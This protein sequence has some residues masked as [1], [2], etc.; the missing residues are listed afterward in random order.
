MCIK[1][2]KTTEQYK[3]NKTATARIT[4]TTTAIHIKTEITVERKMKNRVHVYKVI[5]MVS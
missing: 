4:P 5:C 3:T 2:H 1:Q